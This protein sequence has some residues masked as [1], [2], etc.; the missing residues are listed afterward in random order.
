MRTVTTFRA[1]TAALLL[2]ACGGDG[3]NG[4]GPGNQLQVTN[5][6]D[7]FQLQVTSMH[8]V[9]ETLRYAWTNTGDSASINQATVVT[10]GTATLTVRGADSTVVYQSDLTGNGT[11]Q[12]TLSTAG[13]WFI[14]L[15]LRQADG[16]VNFRVQKAP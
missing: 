10:G 4:I 5:A 13:T 9:T 14:E 16:D 7:D 11:F 15:R 2:A 8:N 3:S 6:A 12:S 1:L